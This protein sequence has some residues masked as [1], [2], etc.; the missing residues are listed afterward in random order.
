M[1]VNYLLT[2]I[3][4]LSITFPCGV[5]AEEPLTLQ[6]VVG[7]ALQNNKKYKINMEKTVESRNK[8]LESW[9]M[10][11]PQLQTD[12][13]Y[14]PESYKTGI[15]NTIRNQT[16]FTL[17]DSQISINPGVFYNTLQSSRHAHIVAEYTARQTRAETALQAIN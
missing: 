6:T 7:M 17:I 12:V 1:K 10:L 11:W 13:A 8:I 5:I 15:F 2:L 3:I 9:G 16:S 14:E 4:L